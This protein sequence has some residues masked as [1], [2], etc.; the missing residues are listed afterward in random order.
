[1]TG[2]DVLLIMD[3]MVFDVTNWLHEHPGGDTIIPAQA[4]NIDSCRF[5]ELYHAS[6]ESF[7]YLRE[8]YIGEVLPC[9]RDAVPRSDVE[10]SDDFLVQL[11]QWTKEFRLEEGRAAAA[12]ESAEQ[13][14]KSF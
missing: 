1:M 10:P 6:R 9:D 8:F 2:G 4:L 12:A 13:T 11:R 14:F 3:G 5:F 7:V